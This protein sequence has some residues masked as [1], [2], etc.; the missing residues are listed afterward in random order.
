VPVG[1]I[2]LT[3][4][5]KVEINPNALS[6]KNR[7]KKS[8]L[9][10]L[11]KGKALITKEPKSK[12]TFRLQLPKATLSVKGTKIFLNQHDG[13]V[14]EAALLD[15]KLEV[16]SLDGKKKVKLKAGEYVRIKN[17]N[18]SKH[19]G[20]PEGYEE[21]GDYIRTVPTDEK[22]VFFDPE[23][24][25]IMKHRTLP[26]IFTTGTKLVKDKYGAWLTWEKPGT[27]R[28]NSKSLFH[29]LDLLYIYKG[30]NI[31]NYRYLEVELKGHSS[32]TYSIATSFSVNQ[33]RAYS[34]LDNDI[35]PSLKKR[36]VI[37]SLKDFR[38]SDK[39]LHE[40]LG[41]PTVMPFT[42][43]VSIRV[44]VNGKLK[45]KEKV[46]SLVKIILHKDMPK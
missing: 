12:S 21:F 25:F 37:L 4:G 2:N 7:Y 44:I 29:D 22:W 9:M 6:K 18:I 46:V 1:S 41:K 45:A 23:S 36:S 34:M 33:N 11:K 42:S 13:E 8:L 39:H 20:T 24:E 14:G 28:A 43:G 32:H 19:K 27:P 38:I 15:G 30:V 10:K 17:E 16:Y 26:R 40:A 31:S 35:K 5:S 3:G